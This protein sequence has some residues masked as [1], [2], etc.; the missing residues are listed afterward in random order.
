MEFGSL[1]GGGTE[2]GEEFLDWPPRATRKTPNFS[3]G[4]PI[5]R[6]G[7]SGS[8]WN[9]TNRKL[10]QGEEALPAGVFFLPKMKLMAAGGRA[11]E[12]EDDWFPWIRAA[13]AIPG[14]RAADES[15]CPP[16]SPL[17]VKLGIAGSLFGMDGGLIRCEGRKEK[18]FAVAALVGSFCRKRGLVWP[19]AA[20]TRRSSV[21]VNADFSSHQ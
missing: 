18:A 6:R 15:Y 10:E 4:L 9:Q 21:L 14:R 12:Q 1:V 5:G 20:A 3:R 17:R 11:V 16:S 7:G 19:A 2:K 8:D 13:A